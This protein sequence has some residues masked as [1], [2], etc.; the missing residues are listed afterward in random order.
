MILVFLSRMKVASI[1][2]SSKNGKCRVRKTFVNVVRERERKTKMGFPKVVWPNLYILLG[3]IRILNM[4]KYVKYC[5][6]WEFVWFTFPT[7]H[8][9][10]ILL[11]Y[12][13]SCSILYI[14]KTVSWDFSFLQ[15]VETIVKLVI[16]KLRNQ[17]YVK[18]KD[19]W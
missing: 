18:R 6:K 11:E 14:R 15:Y 8:E 5:K 12:F 19:P 3:Q 7:L 2:S 1:F 4:V 16:N 13:V 9:L 10:R 17:K